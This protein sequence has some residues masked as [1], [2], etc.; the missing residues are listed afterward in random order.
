MTGETTELIVSLIL[1]VSVLLIAV[2]SLVL[3][4]VVKRLLAL[5]DTLKTCLKDNETVESRAVRA[6][7]DAKR[8]N[9]SLFH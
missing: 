7:V 6:V 1:L 3:M 9:P 8:R 4:G 5:G 2:Q